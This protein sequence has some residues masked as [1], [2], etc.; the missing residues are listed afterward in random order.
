MKQ[1]LGDI[2]S[3]KMAISIRGFSGFWPLWALARVK[4]MYF[5]GEGLLKREESIYKTSV[6]FFP[7]LSFLGGHKTF[8]R[9]WK[10]HMRRAVPKRVVGVPSTFH[11]D[12]DGTGEPYGG[13]GVCWEGCEDV[14][15][16]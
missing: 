9:E 8:A 5:T 2:S 10:R 13:G 16:P 12:E 6:F 14:L 3:D 7:F 15:S 11:P 1:C 4:G